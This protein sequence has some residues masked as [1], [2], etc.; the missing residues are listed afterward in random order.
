[1]PG[2]GP[3]L[4]VLAS[5]LVDWR[6]AQFLD[7]SSVEGDLVPPGTEPSSAESPVGAAVPTGSEIWREYKREDIPPLFGASFNP[8]SW[9]AGIVMIERAKAMILLV[10][11]K[12]GALAFGNHYGDRLE[13][14]QT[15]RWR[16]RMLGE[17]G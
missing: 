10:T 3:V 5:E 1:M 12:K 17:W 7:R 6:L 11:L 4:A 13:D 15:F 8:G 16:S 2:Q 14:E 9:N